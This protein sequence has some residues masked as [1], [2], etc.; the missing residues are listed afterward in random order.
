MNEQLTRKCE[1][2]ID[3]REMLKNCFKWSSITD[4]CCRA[5][6]LLGENDYVSEAQI[7]EIKEYI[8]KNEGIFSEL[9]SHIE[10]SLCVKMAL[11]GNYVEY[12]E[13]LKA[14]MRE[15]KTSW[16]FSSS[17]K[18]VSAMIIMENKEPKEFRR[19]I[20]KTKM[21]YEQM[22][23]DHSWLT[24]DYDMIFAALL[25][26]SDINVDNILLEMDEAFRI[27]KEQFRSSQ[28]QEL[29]HILA[30][31]MSSPGEKTN[32]FLEIYDLLKANGIKVSKYYHLEIL[33][34][35]S[36]LEMDDADIIDQINQAEL[37]LSSYPKFRGWNMFSDERILYAIMLVIKNNCHDNNL[38]DNV[39]LY[40][41]LRMQRSRDAAAAAAAA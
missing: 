30:L 34:V 2:F 16:L 6:F 38:I 35:L 23:R 31:N 33:A 8:K 17:Y 41:I 4:Q 39:L 29:S 9:R 13:V 22:K 32:R 3:S 15:I 26:V 25:A 12:Y 40:V 27:L 24:A 28:N 10:L 11:S 5:S 14:I 1:K 7:N 36:L 20:D 21:I 37:Y 19:Y 18:A